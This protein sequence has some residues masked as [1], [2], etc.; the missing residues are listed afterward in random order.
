MISSVINEEILVM[1]VEKFD[2][3][4]ALTNQKT[5]K[6]AKDK[7]LD[8]AVA[9]CMVYVKAFRRSTYVYLDQF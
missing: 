1:F 5:M 6:A 4:E 9:V 7:K 3:V 8:E 2:S